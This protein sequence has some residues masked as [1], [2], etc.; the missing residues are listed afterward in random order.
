MPEPLPSELRVPTITSAFFAAQRQE[1][2]E[3][4]SRRFTLTVPK[5]TAH[6][7]LSRV[8]NTIH[9]T[10]D[11]RMRQAGNSSEDL[12]PPKATSCHPLERR[13]GAPA[14]WCQFHRSSQVELEQLSQAAPSRRTLLLRFLD[15]VGQ[16]CLLLCLFFHLLLH[17]QHGRLMLSGAKAEAT[18]IRVFHNTACPQDRSKRLSLP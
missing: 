12:H 15:E 11:S 9:R 7:C 2:I 14:P 5:H 6:D 3:Q 1:E 10:T 16:S 18:L 8:F 17:R 13:L 4:S